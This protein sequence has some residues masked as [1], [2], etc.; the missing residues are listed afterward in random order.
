MFTDTNQ[1]SEWESI[2]NKYKVVSTI[3]QGTYG[4]VVKA[5]HIKTGTVVAIKKIEYNPQDQVAV[6]HI[7]REIWI[8]KVLSE[9]NENIFTTKLY[10]VLYS[11]CVSS[12]SIQR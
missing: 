9:I 1:D 10:E 2:S 11:E 7:N 8:M 3:G 12:D 5:E 4:K 6:K